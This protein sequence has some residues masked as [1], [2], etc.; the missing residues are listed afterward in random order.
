M[1]IWFQMLAT[2]PATLQ[3]LIARRNRI[4]L[5]HRATPAI[6]LERLRLAL[7]HA[8]TVRATYFA[9]EKDEQAALQHL[10]EV[11]GGLSPDQLV[12][13]YGPV[14]PF[15]QIAAA[16]NPQSL[17][18]RLILH[19]FL[20]P[21]P[22]TNRHPARFLLPPEVRQ[23][24]PRPLALDDFGAAPPSTPAP[25]LRVA[26]TI[27]LACAERP[28]PLCQD[29]LLRLESLR[30]LAAHLA[31]FDDTEVAALCRFVLPLLIDLGL[32]A[33]H[34]ASAALAPQGARFLARPPYEQL[35]RLR[36]AWV[37]MP[38]PDAWLRPLLVT[39][40]GLDWPLLRRRLLAWAAALPPSQ[41]LDPTTLY[42]ALTAALGPLADAHTH[43]FRPVD[44]APW[45]PKRAEAIW[46]AALRGP[47]TWLG[48]IAWVEANDTQTPRCFATPVARAEVADADQR[49]TT[50]DQRPTTNKKTNGQEDKETARRSNLQSAIYNLQSE[51]ATDDGHQTTDNWR[52]GALGD[53][54]IPHAVLDAAV[55]RLL[56]YTRWYAADAETTTYRITPRRLAAAVRDGYSIDALATLLERQAGP[57][58]QEWR[59]WLTPAP[60]VQIVYGAV[61][62]SDQADR[63]RPRG[64]DAQCAPL[65]ASPRA[66][67]RAGQP[68]AR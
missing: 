11:R 14:R 46:E 6:R 63:A 28:L 16:I 31:P 62:M 58:P 59:A 54:E 49:P 40:R 51:R 12:A 10:R 5:P 43:G 65:S 44:R 27:L 18:E 23:W 19:G 50:N 41:L 4:S 17:S 34:G 61:V 8:A 26:T 42:D 47:L 21:R 2:A 68:R 37:G 55:L 32:L 9:M 66:R 22:A 52:Y 39:T 29:G 48:S 24:L 15:S 25:A 3:R 45:Q 57:L 56:P 35:A 30:R 60:A 36:A 53:I 64:A 13:L 67:H 1:N 20:L 33:P 38:R 7:C